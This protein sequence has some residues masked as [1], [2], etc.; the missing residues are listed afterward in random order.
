[1]FFLS[2]L[3]QGNTL[4]LTNAL[5]KAVMPV[6]RSWYVGFKKTQNY[7]TQG[8]EQSDM[9]QLFFTCLIWLEDKSQARA[10]AL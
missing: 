5:P 2:P 4:S 10:Q 6:R 7:S 8:R 3:Y 1:M 9:Q